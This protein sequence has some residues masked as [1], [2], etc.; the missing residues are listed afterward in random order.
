MILRLTD[1]HTGRPIRVWFGPRMYWQ[2]LHDEAGKFICTEIF[3]GNYGMVVASV[4]ESLE[5][6]DALLR[7]AK[8][9]G[10]LIV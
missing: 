5:A 7:T 2:E 6:I 3:M 9:E 4:R 1:K 10:F 8:R